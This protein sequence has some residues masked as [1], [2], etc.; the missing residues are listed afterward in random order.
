MVV[1]CFFFFFSKKEEEE[2]GEEG[3]RDGDW[4][5]RREGD[6]ENGIEEGRGRGIKK[7]RKKLFFIV[8][9]PHSNHSTAPSAL[10]AC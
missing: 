10:S 3:E 6:G 5:G 8:P 4:A 2:E 7:E 9:R 1:M